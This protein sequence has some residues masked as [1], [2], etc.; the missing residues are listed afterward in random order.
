[1]KRR[2]DHM[3]TCPLETSASPEPLNYVPRSRTSFRAHISFLLWIYNLVWTYSGSNILVLIP[4]TWAEVAGERNPA[5]DL[6]RGS[7][8]ETARMD[9]RGNIS[10][11]PCV[12]DCAC[13]NGT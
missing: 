10:S 9:F 13:G 5:G 11:A 7:R 12:I 1:M 4:T 6:G 8:P 3:T 2:V